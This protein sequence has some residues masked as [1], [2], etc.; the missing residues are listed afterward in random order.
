MVLVA[1]LVTVPSACGAPPAPAAP[2]PPS[3][4]S[5]DFARPVDIGNGRTI[6]LECH[7]AN[8]PGN[9][10]V[11]L[12]SGYRDSGDAWTID[13]VIQ[14]PAV[15]PA[16]PAGLARAIACA[17]TTGRGRSATRSTATR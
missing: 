9:S 8:A 11:V 12:I 16:V 17:P 7:G 4:A 3:G 13:E 6:F 14:P 5:G 15:G 10:T 2:P 1:V